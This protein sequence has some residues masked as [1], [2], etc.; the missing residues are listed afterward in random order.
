MRV[1]VIILSII[2]FIRT[3]SYGIF[4]IK[5]KN[6]PGGIAVVFIAIIALVLPNL[7]VYIRGV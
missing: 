2:I 1:L 5:D 7:V 6:K 3:I 4:E